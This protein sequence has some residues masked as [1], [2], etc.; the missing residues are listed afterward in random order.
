MVALMVAVALVAGAGIG[1]LLAYRAARERRLRAGFRKELEAD[2]KNIKDASEG[3]VDALSN[4]QTP[5]DLDILTNS[6]GKM[7]KGLDQAVKHAGRAPRSMR[8]IAARAEAAAGSLEGYLDL[9]LDLSVRKDPAEVGRQNPVLD[10]RA[11]KARRDLT[12]L[13]GEAPFLQANVNSDFFLAAE[14]LAGAFQSPASQAAE[15]ERQVVHETIERAMEAGVMRFEPEVIWPMVSVTLRTF[16][17]LLGVT[18]EEFA[19]TWRAGWLKGEPGDYYVS[20]N[21]ITFQN[22]Y[23]AFKGIVYPAE[24]APVIKTVRLVKEADGWKI[25]SYPY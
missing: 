21:S 25:D 1:V 13:A 9:V 2:W 7:R 12:D 19:G 24:G 20:P 3:V 5:S 10:A 11:I 15:A 17:E 6:A 22:G 4:L 8:S 16:L 23:A 14:R 18:G